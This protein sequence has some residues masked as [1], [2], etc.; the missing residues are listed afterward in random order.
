MI[1][2]TDAENKA[3]THTQVISTANQILEWMRRDPG[4]WG[5][6]EYGLNS[7]PHC[8]ALYDDTFGVTT[9]RACSTVIPT[10]PPACTFNWVAV[11]DPNSS[12]LAHLAVEVYYVGA[13][14]QTERY[15]V[16]GMARQT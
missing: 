9:P 11:E 13:N 7:C 6:G 3:G 15:I 2:A 14:H 16:M 5:P 1:V 4:F 12:A 8:W 10:A